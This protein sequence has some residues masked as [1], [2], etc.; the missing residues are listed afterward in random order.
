MKAEGRAHAK[1][2]GWEAALSGQW[3]ELERRGGGVEG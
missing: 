1:A 2:L 3:W